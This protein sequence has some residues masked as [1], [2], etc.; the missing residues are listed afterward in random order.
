MLDVD[1]LSVA[2]TL[3]ESIDALAASTYLATVVIYNCKM[4]ITSVTIVLYSVMI[5]DFRGR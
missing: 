2:I 4:Y 5:F 3:Y 1:M